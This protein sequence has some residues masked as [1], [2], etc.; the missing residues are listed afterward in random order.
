MT[1]YSFE[2]I[3]K[4]FIEREEREFIKKNDFVFEEFVSRLQTSFADKA[5]QK[6]VA[7]QIKSILKRL[8]ADVNKSVSLVEQW[9]EKN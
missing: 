4:K 6:M 2:A 1:F 5:E 8:P 9:I 3:C 7:L